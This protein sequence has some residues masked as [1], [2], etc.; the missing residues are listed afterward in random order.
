MYLPQN[1][2]SGLVVTRSSS[3]SGL[4]QSPAAK[5]EASGGFAP[6]LSDYDNTGNYLIGG[7]S[8]RISSLIAPRGYVRSYP[9]RNG[10]VRMR[11]AVNWE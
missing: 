1:G 8:F 10:D 11:I 7:T 4:P 2:R 6:E 3:L 9:H 5:T